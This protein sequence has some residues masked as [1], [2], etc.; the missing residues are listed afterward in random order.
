MSIHV[1]IQTHE[2]TLL[3]S[4]DTGNQERK[5]LGAFGAALTLREDGSIQATWRT[6]GVPA[7]TAQILAEFLGA[8]PAMLATVISLTQLA[9]GGHVDWIR[10]LETAL[11][12]VAPQSPTLSPTT[13]KVMVEIL[14]K[15]LCQCGHE[16][17]Q[18]QGTNWPNTT[19]CRGLGCSCQAYVARG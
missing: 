5:A 14:A 2:G 16:K 17:Q 6:L 4:D 8:N 11:L 19:G 1:Q 12:E 3:Y 18:H 15:Q 13:G 9:Q 7:I 10:R